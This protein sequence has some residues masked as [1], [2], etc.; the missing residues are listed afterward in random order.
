MFPGLPSAS[1][2]VP[3]GQLKR[4]PSLPRQARGTACRSLLSA[5]DRRQGLGISWSVAVPKSSA[6][7]PCP[8]VTVSQQVS[9]I[10]EAWRAGGGGGTIA[11]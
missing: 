10:L 6:R 2:S 1:V 5:G 11:A 8:R 7:W 3:P 4:P 9:G